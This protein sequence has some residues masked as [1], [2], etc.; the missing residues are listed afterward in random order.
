M[1]DKK[2]KNNLQGF[3]KVTIDTK[4]VH[5]SEQQLKVKH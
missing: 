2:K 5:A 3:G 4:Q 1:K